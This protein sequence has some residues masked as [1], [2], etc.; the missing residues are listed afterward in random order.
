MGNPIAFNDYSVR[1]EALEAY[2][3]FIEPDKQRA[4][5]K[6]ARLGSDSKPDLQLLTVTTSRLRNI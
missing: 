2:G 1:P 5:P 4:F 6:P 3:K